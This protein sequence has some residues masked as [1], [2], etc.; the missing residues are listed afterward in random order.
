MIP[1]RICFELGTHCTKI[2][3][4]S[5]TVTPWRQSSGK[6]SFSLGYDCSVCSLQKAILSH[7]EHIFIEQ[8]R[9]H[10]Q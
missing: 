5:F 6:M 7:S 2:N 8:F 3:L 1:L 4:L 10:L 9:K